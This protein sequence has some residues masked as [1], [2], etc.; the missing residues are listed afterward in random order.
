[1]TAPVIYANYGTLADFKYLA[2]HGVSVK[3][4]IVLVRYGADFRGVKVYI[5]QQFGAAGMLIYS[6]PSDDG[7]FLGDAYPRGPYRPEFSVQRG[8]TQFLPIYPR[9][10]RDPRRSFHAGSARRKTYPAQ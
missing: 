2:A 8:S 1:M 6:D 5:A 9:R 7:Y 4:K 10:S 3:G